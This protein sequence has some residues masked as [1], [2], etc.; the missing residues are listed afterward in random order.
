M[1]GNFRRRLPLAIPGINQTAQVGW[2]LAQALLKPV[3]FVGRRRLYRAELQFGQ[4]ELFQPRPVDLFTGKA[5]KLGAHEAPGD[6]PQ[7]GAERPPRVKLQDVPESKHE[8]LVG[9]FIRQVRHRQLERH[10]GPQGRQMP[11]YQGRK[12]LDIASLHALQ[13]V[14]VARVW[15]FRLDC[16]HHPLFSMN[17]PE[18]YSMMEI[19]SDP[20]RG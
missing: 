3:R 17:G 12:G 2:E 19:V 15:P 20:A 6:G 10:E 8:G 1:S 11:S 14:S 16:L 13:K 7:P 18:C 9:N 4:L 5:L